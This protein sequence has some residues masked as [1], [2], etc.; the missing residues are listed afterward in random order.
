MPLKI[1]IPKQDLWDDS[2]GEFIPIKE[3]NLTLEHSLVSLTKWESK[4]C[5]PF[6]SP[7]EKTQEEVKDYVRC[8]ILNEDVEDEIIFAFTP[9]DLK[10]VEAYI[11]RNQTATTFPEERKTSEP[12]SN[13]LMTSELIYYYLGQMQCLNPT[14]ENWHLS[15]VLTLIRVASFKNKGEQKLNK[16]EALAQCEDIREANMRKFEEWKRKQQSKMKG[17]K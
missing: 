6:L 8:M 2:R 15:R 11:S 5:K 14:I 1:F 12:Q 7:E 3:H 13:E 10:E 17:V 16:T 9:K 4:W